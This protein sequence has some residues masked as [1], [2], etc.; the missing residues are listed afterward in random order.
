LKK[1]GGGQ[2]LNWGPHLVDWAVQFVGGKAADVWADLKLIAAAGNAEDHVK[3]MIRG[4]TGIIA[5]IEISGAMAITQP[6]WILMGTSGT[7][8]IDAKNQC[9][10][11]YFDPK[12]LPK[13]KASGA[14]PAGR[15]G[16]HFSGGEEIRWIEEQFPAAPATVSNFWVELYKSIRK[17]AAFPITLA[18]AREN[19]RVISLAKKGTRF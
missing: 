11:K 18:Q 1:F 19:M 14:T 9:R 16:S 10:L 8:M 4:E 15:G 12:G 2:L 5:D 6:P 7:L 3:L 17:G 13:V